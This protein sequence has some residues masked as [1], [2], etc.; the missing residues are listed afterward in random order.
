MCGH[1]ALW[2]YSIVSE[3][4][5]TSAEARKNVDCQL[6]ACPREQSMNPFGTIATSAHYI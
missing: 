6:G 4:A 5:S 1:L 3:V 2:I